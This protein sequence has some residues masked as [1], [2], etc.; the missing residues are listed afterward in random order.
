MSEASEAPAISNSALPTGDGASGRHLS[1]YAR[2]L[3]LSPGIT[4]L[5]II[6]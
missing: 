5:G 3:R 6:W 4:H 2:T 1:N